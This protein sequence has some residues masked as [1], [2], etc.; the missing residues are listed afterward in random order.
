MSKRTREEKHWNRYL[1]GN[2]DPHTHAN[3][4][5]EH[6]AFAE[7]ERQ[8]AY[9]RNHPANVKPD[10]LLRFLSSVM[11]EWRK[12]KGNFKTQMEEI[13]EEFDH[14]LEAMK[15]R[16][17]EYRRLKGM[18]KE[19]NEKLKQQEKRQEAIEKRLDLIE[20]ERY[21]AR[22]RALE[23]RNEAIET[24]NG[25][26]ND[27][28]CQKY[29]MEDLE[30]ISHQLNAMDNG[31][32]APE[33]IQGVA[34]NALN[35]IHALTML[36]ERQKIEFA[37]AQL[38]ADTEATLILD[39]FINWRDNVYFDEN[40]QNKADMDFWSF[41]YFGKVM[42]AA[43]ALCH[44]IRGGELVPGYMVENLEDDIREMKK[45]QEEGERT[46]SSVFN[47]CNIS[48]ECEQLGLLTAIILYEDF[49]FQLVAKGY[50]ADDLRHGYVIEMENHSMGC[51][52][53]FIF[54]PVSQT[55]SVGCYQM[56]FSDYI[57][58]QLLSSFEQVLLRELH[59]NGI[60]VH[61]P[62]K[63]DK[64]TWGNIVKDIDFTPVGSPINLP[65]EMRLWEHTQIQN[66]R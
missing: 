31:Q 47:S 37:A 50:D 11:E 48:E 56:C 26:V 9:Y 61:I 4:W 53:R 51:K 57:D 49:H 40:K 46:V 35:R 14:M 45:L 19:L 17:K 41:Q 8:L 10:E 38:L 7:L 54:S 52:L 5:L 27:P 32:L 6:G 55:Q 2:W 65:E 25:I 12:D 16:E 3:V 59:N 22:E 33:A 28:Y 34:I 23:L 29:A 60:Q 30:V 44:R 39:Q 24:F 63:T 64:D 21:Q 66:G 13:L 20:N 36:V 58:L 18:L 1:Y 15:S 43:N 42:S 62:G